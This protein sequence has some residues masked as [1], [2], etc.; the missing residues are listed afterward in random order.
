MHTYKR[1][2]FLP[3]DTALQNTLKNEL[4]IS[5]VLA[6]IL[7]NRGVTG[8][9]E[10][11]EFF[12]SDLNRLHDPY[13]FSDM[14]KAVH[15]IRN[16][17]YTK[18]KVMIF[19]DYDVDGITSV[20]LLKTTLSQLG[21]ESQSYV[22]NR[23]KEGYGLHKNI[24]HIAKEKNIKLLITVDCGTNSH[25][26]IKELR[27]AHID[28][29]LTD[30]HELSG[31]SLPEASAVINPKLKESNYKYRDLAGVGVT[32][33][34]CQALTGDILVDDL[35]LVCVGTIAD[36]VP[37][38]GEN[39]VIAKI[40]LS[41]LSETK[42]IGLKALIENSRIE[43]KKI[44]S[45]AISY[46]L[47]PR[48]NASGRMDTAEISLKLLMTKDKSEAD[49]LAK[50]IEKYN[51]QRQSVENKIL[52]EALHIIEREVNFKD[53]KIIVVANEGWHQGVLGIV[54]A[55]LVD[56]F[57]RPT[58]IISLADGI[59]KGS[60]RSIRNFHLLSALLEC[61][62]L[63]DTFGGHS[64]AVGLGITKENIGDFKKKIN[65]FAHEK[66]RFEDLLPCL[67]IDVEL[68]LSEIND[69]LFAEL[70][71]LEPFGA[72]NPRPLFYTRHLALK[73]APQLLGKD[74]IK[75]WASD[76]KVTLLAIGFGKGALRESL[77]NAD[78]FDLAY[79]LRCDFWQ[80][81][82]SVILEVKDLFCF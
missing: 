7:I 24:L 43:N 77:V 11:R 25:E 49:E 75:F 6:Q 53:H 51:R 35:D 50:L 5:R 26:L 21:I 31:A 64:H 73:G 9:Q 41:G 60:G 10:A 27:R 12:S 69:A 56:R 23:I 22:P 52:Q 68:S 15:I 82:T 58:I 30:H 57:Y 72:G 8:R 3:P 44:N 79:V 70:E 62:E 4:G 81:K 36:V 19:G 48:I 14:H 59:C 65:H 46:I 40:G 80:G 71:R 34:L 38:T 45:M 55:K 17:A 76:G 37:L 66:L 32:Y 1:L 54:A 33:K 78:Y 28:I 67:D 16:V 63:L 13:L 39:R 2:K 20:A 42:K 29:I 61:R 18:E 47:G 74:T